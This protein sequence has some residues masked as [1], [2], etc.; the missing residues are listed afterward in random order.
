[1]R[2]CSIVLIL[3]VCG[4]PAWAEECLPTT[5]SAKLISA[6]RTRNA[7]VL[8]GPKALAFAEEARSQGI[9]M[10]EPDFVFL[11]LAADQN[12]A[13]WLEGAAARVSVTC[14]WAAKP[15]SKFGKLIAR[16]AVP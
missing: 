11:D 16:W 7:V 6:A 10:P 9:P 4:Q 15:G 5:E 14:S 2:L 3:A 1:M 12:E 13:E 8:E